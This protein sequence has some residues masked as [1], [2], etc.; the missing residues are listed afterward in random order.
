MTRYNP[1]GTRVLGKRWEF[2][3]AI[4]DANKQFLDLTNYTVT[5]AIGASPSGPPLKT[6]TATLA[7]QEAE[8]G[9]ATAVFLPTDTAALTIPLSGEFYY[10]ID[11][12][13]DSANKDTLASGYFR[14]QKSLI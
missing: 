7:D 6:V 5:M 10:Q 8:A 4:T 13:L 1:P 12:S 3:L 9:K 2:A 11:A 14:A